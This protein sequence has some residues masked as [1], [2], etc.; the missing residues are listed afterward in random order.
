MSSMMELLYVAYLGKTVWRRT[1]A[2]CDIV[3][4][5]GGKDF[6]DKYSTESDTIK[7][8]IKQCQEKG[9]EF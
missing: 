9:L 6:F 2:I 3:R 7:K 5:H 1:L 8:F 4:K